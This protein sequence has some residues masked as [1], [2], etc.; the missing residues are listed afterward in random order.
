MTDY[1]FPLMIII[2]Y[3]MNYLMLYNKNR[4]MYGIIFIGLSGSTLFMT[5]GT[6]K[7]YTIF[8]IVLIVM[9]VISLMY[10]HIQISDKKAK[11]L[12]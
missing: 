12:G 10:D 4:M 5:Y 8:T 2:G 6:H 7:E 9:G 11:D 1:T 3:T